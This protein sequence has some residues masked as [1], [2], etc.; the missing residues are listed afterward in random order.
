MQR[1]EMF[2]T[3]F[4]LIPFFSIAGALHISF[5]PSGTPIALETQIVAW[6]RDKGDPTEQFYLQKIK[7]DNGNAPGPPSAPVGV[8]DSMSEGGT[9]PMV[10]NQVGLFQVVAVGA[11]DMKTLFSTE[12]T[13][14]QNPSLTEGPSSTVPP[15]SIST[16]SSSTD[17]KTNGL[18]KPSPTSAHPSA[19]DTDSA[20]QSTSRKHAAIIIGAVVGAIAFFTIVGAI[21]L[22]LRYRTRRATT[23]FF[24][25]RMANPYPSERSSDRWT[26]VGSESEKEAKHPYSPSP[27]ARANTLRPQDSVSNI[28]G[29]RYTPPILPPIPTA[30][31][32]VGRDVP[33][34]VSSSSSARRAR[35]RN[36]PRLS[37]STMTSS[38]YVS[39]SL[40]SIPPLPP[41][42]RTDRQMMIEEDIQRLQA[43]MLLLLEGQGGEF[44]EG[45]VLSPTSRLEREEELKQIHVRV[46]RL[47]EIHES[48][49]ALGRTDNVPDGLF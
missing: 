47:K 42:T 14:V 26:V 36:G 35:E 17:K 43:R 41:R 2:F 22:Y 29:Q 9:S 38:S 25:A 28:H 34:S 19:S 27:I 10:F 46:D 31:F 24:Q 45:R 33:S 20:A 7:L 44:Q 13:V 16:S 37:I 15:S 12:V 4:F 40:F 18:D 8:N 49:W 3:L 11:Q 39:G 32:D 21:L 48:D 6:N 5:P 30:R 1:A 23:N